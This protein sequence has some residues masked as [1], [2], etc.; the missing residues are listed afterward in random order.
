MSNLGAYQ[1]LTTTAKTVGGPKNL[2]LIIAGTGALIY[3]GSEIVV[4]KT[5]KEIKKRT[6]KEQL[7][8]IADT[9]TYTATAE[10]RSNE[11]LEIKIG[12][13]FKVLEIDKDAVLIEKIGDSNNPYFVSAELLKNISNYN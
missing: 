10:G 2:V 7:A 13:R 6:S 1:W 12:D 5:V 9:R 3:K 8:K 4:K 11:G